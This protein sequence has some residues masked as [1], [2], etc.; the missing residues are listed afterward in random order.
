[1]HALG[2]GELQDHAVHRRIGVE[3]VDG[4]FDFRRDRGGIARAGDAD[5]IGLHARLAGGA[6]LGGDVGEGGRIVAD[7]DRGQTRDDAAAG[8]L[9]DLGRN[10]S[11]D[12]L[13][14]DIAF[15]QRGGHSGM[16]G[17]AG[18]CHNKARATG[19]Q[20]RPW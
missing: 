6:L 12:L 7:E 17:G 1:M 13:R 4:R 10:L 8:Q 9:L 19:P 15:D 3:T 20:T 11:A 5:D 16:L 2:D 18:R 14:N